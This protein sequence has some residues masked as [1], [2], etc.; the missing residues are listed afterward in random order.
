MSVLK[1]KWID[2]CNENDFGSIFDYTS[3]EFNE[4]DE[5]FSERFSEDS[6]PTGLSVFYENIM[7][8]YLLPD[9]QEYKNLWKE[10]RLILLK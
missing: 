2:L 5:L 10:I 9:H 3:E 1:L 4:V 6:S 8:C 7:N